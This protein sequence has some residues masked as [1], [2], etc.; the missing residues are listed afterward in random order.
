VRKEASALGLQV[1]AKPDSHDICFIP[2][3]DTA[4]Y[5]R[6]Q[7]PDAPGE[8]RDAQTGEVVGE[9]SGAFQ[10]TVGQRRGLN[11]GRPAPDGGRRYVV[12]VDVASSTVLVG[13]PRLLRVNRLECDHLL[14]SGP[15]PQGRFRASVQVRAHGSQYPAWVVADSGS[16]DRPETLEIVLDGEILGV[17]PG[18]SAVLYDGTRVI[19]SGTVATTGSLPGAGT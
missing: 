8:I 1:A 2:D 19:G 14:W 3:G 17:A 13:P 6:S 5:L 7:I 11:L 16:P 15:V 18:Q 12:S 4:G 10:Y 9:H